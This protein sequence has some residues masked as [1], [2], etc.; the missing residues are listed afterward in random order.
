[1]GGAPSFQV[2]DQPQDYRIADPAIMA[3]RL[4]LASQSKGM[5]LGATNLSFLMSMAQQKRKYAT[6]AQSKWL[7][8][9]E[10]RIDAA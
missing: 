1:M 2:N 7:R 3:A 6:P 5:R 8:D 4:L 9:L 10:A